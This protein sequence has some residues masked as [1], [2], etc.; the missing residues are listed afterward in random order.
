LL[1]VVAVIVVH[2]VWLL[3]RGWFPTSDAPATRQ[4]TSSQCLVSRRTPR[5]HVSHSGAGHHSNE[6][7]YG[8]IGKD[9]PLK[10]GSAAN[11]LQNHFP[12][13][14]SS[15]FLNDSR[16]PWIGVWVEI[17]MFIVYT[18][19]LPPTL[20]MH[21]VP[22]TG[23]RPATQ[24]LLL[25]FKQPSQTYANQRTPRTPQT[26]RVRTLEHPRLVIVALQKSGNRGI[27][28]KVWK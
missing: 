13:R 16:L 27:S 12:K 25:H 7:P 21:P 2:V 10:E 19:Y 3:F 11:V 20:L 22:W 5:S 28:K 1:V 6:R 23:H 26:S 15:R 14:R 18:F 8:E 24:H 4:E 17:D 9:F